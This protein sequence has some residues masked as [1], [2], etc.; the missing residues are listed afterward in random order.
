MSM[1]KN[2]HPNVRTLKM[3]AGTGNGKTLFG[4]FLAEKDASK[5]LTRCVGKTNSTI[6]ERLIVYTEYTDKT[7]KMTVAVRLNK[8]A[9]SWHRFTEIFSSAVASIIIGTDR[10]GTPDGK[11]AAMDSLKVALREELGRKNNI[12]AVLS[13]L[14]QDQIENFIQKTADLY[15]SSKLW[16]ESGDIYNA[17]KNSLPGVDVKKR[18]NQ[19]LTA[20]KDEVTRTLDSYSDDWK[21]GFSSLWKDLNHQLCKVFWTYFNEEDQSEDGYYYKDIDLSAPDED[22]IGKMFTANNTQNGEDLSLEVLCKEIILYVPMAAK[23]ADVIRS[24]PAA[25]KVFAD[26]H[27]NLVFGLID[28][29][30][31]FHASHADDEN[32]DYASDLIYQDSADAVIMLLPLW[33]D[34]NEKRAG[35]LYRGALKDSNKQ[36][37]IFVVHNKLDLFVDE[38]DKEMAT[39]KI[40]DPLSTESVE[41]VAL[42][43]DMIHQAVEKRMEELDG[44]LQNIELRS[45]KHLDLMSV[46]CYMRRGQH[47]PACLVQDYNV[48]EAYRCIFE[49]VAERLESDAQKIQVRLAAPGEDAVPRVDPKRV[50]ALFGTHMQSSEMMKRVFGPGEQNRSSSVGLTPHGNSY[51]ALRRRLKRGEGYTAEI[52]ESYYYNC[53]SFSVGF[54]A[55]I[56]NLLTP[57]FLHDL[58]SQALTIEGGT[59]LSKADHDKFCA[60]VERAVDAK[61]F[62]SILL[63]DRALQDAETKKQ[64]FSFKQKFQNFLENCKG[65]LIPDDIDQEAY[66]QALVRIVEDA[67]QKALDL[68]TV[69]K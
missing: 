67:A 37:P 32:A 64:A 24:N 15:Q 22:F 66:E 34:P 30:G 48:L 19:F 53:R 25:G 38:M 28:T 4:A 63:Y 59:F 11:Q 13:L 60:L 18:K 54:P 68:Y 51:N 21:N 50:G 57:T 23:V 14:S 65:L 39:Q 2:L 29:R 46:A 27:G 62:G 10:A 20:I 40:D 43:Q 5:I 36:V 8:E 42:S 17:A 58:T 12:K 26:S 33:G 9:V 1:R 3:V 52:D 31:L 35:E 41:S 47:F 55:N 44:V 7:D 45:G 61:R 69:F 6:T 49:H 56:K 16:E